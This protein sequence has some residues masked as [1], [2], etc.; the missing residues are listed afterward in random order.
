P[1]DRQRGAPPNRPDRVR[2]LLQPG[3]SA[4]DPAARDTG[5]GTPLNGRSN[6]RPP[7]SRRAAPRVRARRVTTRRLLSPD[8]ASSG[9]LLARVLDRASYPMAARVGTAAGAAHGAA[10]SA[11]HAYAFGLRRVLEGLAA[12]VEPRRSRRPA[13]G[14]SSVENTQPGDWS[15]AGARTESDR[16][17]TVT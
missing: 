12:L 9:P 15:Q 6:P 16:V 14:R 8:R 4:T 17:R 5:A 2:V 11:E 3:A 13:R 1:R 7:R 10:Y